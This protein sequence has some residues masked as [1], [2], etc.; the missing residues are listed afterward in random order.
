MDPLT[1]L[2]LYLIACMGVLLVLI[3]IGLTDGYVYSHVHHL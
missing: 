2:D 1:L 3:I